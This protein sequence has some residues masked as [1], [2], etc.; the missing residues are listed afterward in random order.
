MAIEIAVAFLEPST[1]TDWILFQT[2][3]CKTPEMVVQKNPSRSAVSDTLGPAP[4]SP[5]TVSGI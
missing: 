5:T 1:T 3:P 2:V 4:L